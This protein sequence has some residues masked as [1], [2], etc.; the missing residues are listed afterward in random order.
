MR[1]AANLTAPSTLE[2]LEPRRL[3][4]AG[5]L[6]A[7]FGSGG[8]TLQDI[9]TR[10]DFAFA[11]AIQPDGKILVAGKA[12]SGTGTGN[13][14]AVVRFNP[15]GTLDT[16]FGTGGIVLTDVGSTADVANAIAIQS[17]GKIVLV[18][19]SR[20]GTA[21]PDFAMVRY[22]TDG[23]LDTSFGVGGRV[24]TD[25]SGGNDSGRSVALMADGRIVVAGS[26]T[27]GSVK[28]FALARYSADGVLDSTFN[29]AGKTTTLFTSGSA[30][31]NAVAVLADG[32]V[33]AAGAATNLS[34]AAS[35]LAAV[36]YLGNGA[37][38]A[39]FGS[40]GWLTLDLGGDGDVAYAMAMQSDGKLVIA[41]SNL[42][43]STG[44]SDFCLVRISASGA[45]DTTFGAGGSVVTDFYG[46][47]DQPTSM[48]LAADGRIVVAGLATLSGVTGIGV[49]RYSSDGVADA[50]FGA[51]GTVMHS[52]GL[53]DVASGVAVDGAGDVVV[54]G[55]SMSDAGKFD[56]VVARLVGRVNTAPTANPG[57]SYVVEAGG[58]VLLDGSGSFDPDGS[59]AGYEW[60]L[61]YDGITFTADATGATTS[62]SAAGLS[63]VTRTVGLRV[64]DNEGATHIAMVTVTVNEIV[65]P[66]PDPDPTPDPDPAPEPTPT[67]Q[68]VNDPAS[69]GQKLLILH[70][71]NHADFIRIV[72]LKKGLVQISMNGKCLGKFAN[73]S[74]VRVC[75][76]D[77]NDV[78]NA[79]NA[80]VRM[81]LFGGRGNDQIIGGKLND[82]LCGGDGNDTIFG[83]GGNDL[84]CGGAGSDDL[85]GV[86]G[87]DLL[88]GGSMTC[89]D[90]VTE[91]NTM[92]TAWNGAG[93]IA[94]RFDATKVVDDRSRDTFHGT[95]KKD[96]MVGGSNDKLP[97]S[98][99]SKP[100]KK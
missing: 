44:A 60:D 66:P 34:T 38:D 12:S 79:E 91:L 76:E 65:V 33:V 94:N 42:D 75:G 8:V 37:V 46:E 23:S 83:R 71:T 99:P 96:L 13:D 55:Y 29:G 1:M 53:M 69:A 81:E 21:Q 41:G 27:V 25:F 30:V 86:A 2:S 89:G 47:Y 49:A 63:G 11:T 17:S 9:R 95:S 58:S 36:R 56:F 51:G 45:I 5:D 43:N 64:T 67:L 31:A 68:V 70:G 52:F 87:D 32:S 50:G 15:N 18:G 80:K 59:I 93:S 97:K 28:R 98:K 40:S 57:G 14:F 22:N 84:V 90:N 48:T 73:V 78:I 6:D 62:F 16:T 92:L 72:S 35:D 74:R 61:D 88:V 7:L 39:S 77:G 100:K 26:A 3:F 4:A 20:V 24:L 54:G 10:D 19:E 85:H 82:V